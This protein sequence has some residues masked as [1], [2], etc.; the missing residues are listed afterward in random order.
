[1]RAPFSAGAVD[2]A[3][4]IVHGVGLREA[5]RTSAARSRNGQGAAI[6]S[7]TATGKHRRPTASVAAPRPALTPTGAA[8]AQAATSM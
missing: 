8:P 2:D 1:M 5:R 6:T 7:V 3:L 4:S